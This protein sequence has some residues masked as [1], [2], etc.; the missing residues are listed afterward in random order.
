MLP[1]GLL[2]P[3]Q[4]YLFGVVSLVIVAAIGG[5]FFYEYG[6]RIL[7]LGAVG[8]LVVYFYTT[9][10]T[11]NPWLCAIARHK[12]A[13]HCRRR[14]RT[15]APLSALPPAELAALVDAGPLPE[16]VLA[17]RA[18]RAQVVAVLGALPAEYR[19]AL[20]TR[21]ADGHSV[22]EVA[23]LLGR[24]YKATESLLARAR[25]AF[26]AALSRAEEDERR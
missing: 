17:Q 21:Y 8:V 20:V 26:R 15:A 5:Y 13:D 23:R 1:S 7:P 12:A 6:W 11:R 14:G 19:A 18:V 2:K 3:H 4:V 10:L 16:E 25:A 24:S 9:Y 22:D